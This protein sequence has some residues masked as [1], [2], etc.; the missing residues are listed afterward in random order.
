MVATFCLRFT[1]LRWGLS[2]SNNICGKSVDRVLARST[3]PLQ[4]LPFACRPP[5][6]V[7]NHGVT[8]PVA[9]L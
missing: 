7:G 9:R 4:W 1:F 2:S 8:A 5:S 3:P 6:D